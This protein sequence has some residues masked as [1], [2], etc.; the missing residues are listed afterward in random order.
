MRRI[1]TSPAALV[2]IAAGLASAGLLWLTLGASTDQLAWTGT[3]LARF[4]I[5]GLLFMSGVVVGGLFLHGAPLPGPLG[6]PGGG[7]GGS[8]TPSPDAPPPAPDLIDL[9]L[10]QL[11]AE[12]RA[13][14]R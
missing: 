7:G 1:R 9:E 14:P 6:G 8:E 13:R 12:E 10:E 2:L 11:V 3:L 4:S 5:P